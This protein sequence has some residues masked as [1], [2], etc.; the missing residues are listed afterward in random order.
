MNTME[1]GDGGKKEFTSGME[2]REQGMP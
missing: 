2:D 1:Y